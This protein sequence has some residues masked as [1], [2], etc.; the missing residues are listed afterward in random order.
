MSKP[1]SAVAVAALTGR[2]CHRVS[3]NLYLQIAEGNTRAWVLRYQIDGR[4]RHMG[5]GS[6]KWVS[7]AEARRKAA[8]A[9]R[10]VV[11]GND[12]ITARKRARQARQAEKTFSEC[13]TAYIS[14]HA[15]GWG[16]SNTH[17]W[18][19]SLRN[20]ASTLAPMVVSD[21]DTPAVLAVLEPLWTVKPETAS[22]IRG[23]IE[24]V[25][26]WA[27]ARGFRNGGENPARW[28]G[29][30][31]NLLA[32][33][34]R[35]KRI[36]HFAA[37]P[38]QQIPAFMAELRGKDGIAHQAGVPARG[39]AF[40][41]LTAS[42]S[43][44]VLGARWDEIDGDTWSI[45]AERMKAAKPHRVPLC[46]RARELL[47]G[48]PRRGELI[49]PGARGGAPSIHTF[50]RLLGQMGHD[51][52]THGFRSSFRDWAAET[53][54]FPNHVVEAALAH[55]I[56]NA[57]EAA[58]RRGDLIDKRRELMAAWGDYCSTKLPT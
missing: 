51:V 33:R 44:E 1:L 40:L 13:S 53:T 43:A 18:E 25:L 12:P 15:A 6:A 24:A 21:I 17:Q 27:K 35:I 20:H 2:G 42:R 19:R 9:M 48:Q 56:S 30:L 8:D 29:H 46:D 16:H 50:K 11:E 4:P 52:T 34:S 54:A 7:L 31:E 45:P 22:R 47:A 3:D 41:I 23:R 36:E 39:L 14:S 57:V 26:D 10:M 49:F 38:Y 32:K 28:K 55:T 37:M 5:L 58:Y